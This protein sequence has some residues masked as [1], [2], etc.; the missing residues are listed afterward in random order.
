NT[1]QAIGYISS[2]LV[3]RR[4]KPLSIDGVTPSVENLVN[5]SYKFVRPFLL[6]T[7]GE[8]TG[9]VKSFIEYV[10]SDDAQEILLH[11]GLTPVQNNK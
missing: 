4:V 2:G 5:G 11:E 6:L 10:L 3:D 8:P 9:A 7:K 1:P